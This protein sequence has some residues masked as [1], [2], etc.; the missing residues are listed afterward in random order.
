MIMTSY[1]KKNLYHVLTV[2]LG[3]LN[4]TNGMVFRYPS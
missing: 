4:I 3:K 2:G 1:D